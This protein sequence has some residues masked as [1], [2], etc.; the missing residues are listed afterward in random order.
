MYK[1]KY[2]SFKL[3]FAVM[4]FIVWKA[5]HAASFNC[6]KAQTQVENLI[7]SYSTLSFDDD[8]LAK[9]FKTPKN[10]HLEFDDPLYIE[11]RT[12]LK[13]VRNACTTQAC[14]HIAYQAR[15]DYIKN[16]LVRIFPDSVGN[17]GAGAQCKLERP[18]SIKS[19]CIVLSDCAENSNYSFFQAETS[20]CEDENLTNINEAGVRSIAVYFYSD[21]YSK[22]ILIG[23]LS[24]EV[25]RDI[26]FDVKWLG[27]DANGFATLY[28]QTDCA[29]M[30]CNGSAFRYDAESKVMYH[31]YDGDYSKVYFF[32]D[33]IIESGKDNC[34][35]ID[36]VAHKL[37]RLGSRDVVDDNSIVISTPLENDGH[38]K[39][40][41][42]FEYIGGKNKFRQTILP[43]KK[44]LKYCSTAD[45]KK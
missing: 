8:I 35:T 26:A 31:F 33:Y 16:T 18:I 43:N 30:Q 32:D 22:P 34:C 13:T 1:L 29:D 36:V 38:N 37:H 39:T 15:I 4:L 42:I 3:I 20:Q 44:W 19:G 9:L 6:E 17:L 27:P 5:S 21:K 14:L 11:Q 24:I 45:Y 23:K 25:L 28:I 10:H 7:C 2:I 40:C 12:W 41:R